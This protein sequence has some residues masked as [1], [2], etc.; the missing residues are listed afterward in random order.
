M[1]NNAMKEKDRELWQRI[2]SIVI[3]IE[4][5]GSETYFKVSSDFQIEMKCMVNIVFCFFT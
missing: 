3:Q 1:L 4:V 2:M 5:L